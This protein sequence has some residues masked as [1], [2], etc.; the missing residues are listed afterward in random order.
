M[1]TK[2]GRT[3]KRGTTPP[4]ARDGVARETLPEQET[5]GHGAVG[6]LVVGAVGIV[7]GDIGTSPLYTLKECLR[8]VEEHTHAAPTRDDVLGLMSMLFWSLL[9]VVTV[10]YLLVVMRADYKGEGGIFA[11]LGMTPARFRPMGAAKFGWIPI[12]VVIGAALLYG[13]GVITPAISVLS[14]VEGLKIAKPEWM[15]YTVQ[16]TCVI[17]VGLFAIQSRGT[18]T[19]GRFFGPIMIIWFAT[20]AILGVIQI[21]QNPGVLVGISPTYAIGYFARHGFRGTSIL[22]SVVL[23]VTGGEAL[24]ADMGHFGR[25]P[26]RLAWLGIVWPALLLSY[27]G[28]AALVLAHPEAMEDPFFHLVPEALTVP[29][30]IL[31]SFATV[32]ASQA[33]ISGAYSLTR[34][35]IQL[36]FLPRLAVKHTSKDAEGQIYMPQVNWLLAAACIFIVL[37][38][39][40]SE[41][42]AAAYGLAVTGT[43]GI[44]SIIFGVVAITVMRWSRGATIALVGFFL[45]FDIPFFLANAAKF[46]DG[47]WLPTMIGVAMTALMLLWARGQRLMGKLLFGSAAPMETLGRIRKQ[48]ARTLPGTAVMLA[49]AADIVPPVL[50]QIVDRFNLVHERIIVLNVITEGQHRVPKGQRFTVTELGDGVYQ[51]A[52]RFGFMEEPDVPK[53]LQRVLRKAKLGFEEDEVTYFLR[54][55]NIVGGAGGEM[56]VLAE[57][58]FAFLHRNA[59]SADSYFKLPPERVVELGWQLDL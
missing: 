59:V 15:P 37:S 41:K 35:A 40:S 51:I 31:S 6:A 10:K 38:F 34:Q 13:D 33:L 39:R 29:L 28:Q 30:V 57:N 12:L 17:L 22:G 53:A 16:I 44:T 5:H 54:R 14:A 50:K 32:I 45:M 2:T 24:Y 4:P 49:A 8:S 56:G 26:I 58:I 43:M 36:G 46:R 7:F 9:L 52:L 3:K 20:L 11:L 1:T 48:S 21:S 55:E 42:L 47:G 23:A 19:V 27:F 18:A 25:K